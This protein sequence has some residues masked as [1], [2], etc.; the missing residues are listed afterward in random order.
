MARS[1]SNN[2][3]LMTL[4][5]G[6]REQNQHYPPHI[7]EAHYKLASDWL[8]DEVVKL[9]PTSQVIVDILRP[10]LAIELVPVVSGRVQLPALYRNFLGAGFYAQEEDDKYVPVPLPEKSFKNPKKPTIDELDAVT[11]TLQVVSRK[12]S[13]KTIGEWNYITDHPYKKPSTF[14]KAA[15]CIF[16]PVNLK[17][18]PLKIPYAEIRYVKIFPE[19][20]YGYTMLPDDTFVFDPTT[21]IEEPWGETAIPYLFKAVNKL[22]ANYTRD[23]EYIASS[24]DLRDNSLF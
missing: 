1:I 4:A 19:F 2:V 14:K 12:I 3:F 20:H 8:K 6:N 13:L 9:Y 22:Y 17:V 23:T 16:D 7:F 21:T 11:A 10:Y 5:Q 15:G 24:T 18:L